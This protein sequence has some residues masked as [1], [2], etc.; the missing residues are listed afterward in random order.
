MSVVPDGLALSF[1]VITVEQET[2]LITWLDSQPWS[3]ELK[4]RTQHY[5]YG[6]NYRSKKLVPGPPLDGP[7]L[8]LAQMFERSGLMKPVQCIVNEY[9]RNQGISAHIDRLDFGPDVLGLSIGADTVMVFERGTEKFECFLP[10]RSLVKLSGP[11]RYEWEHSIP[12]RVTYIDNKG[13]KVTKPQDYRRI[14]LTF[15]ELAHN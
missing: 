8:E 2:Q 15:R 6:Y 9:T 10:R 7:I 3:N 13:M 12:S 1:E 4:R 14:S 11:A 5:G